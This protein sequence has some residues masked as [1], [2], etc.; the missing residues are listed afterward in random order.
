MR[1]RLFGFLAIALVSFPLPVV[2]GH[3]YVPVQNPA[4]LLEHLVNH[5]D[6]LVTN[7]NLTRTNG[8]RVV[9]EVVTVIVGPPCWGASFYNDVLAVA[10]Q[11]GGPDPIGFEIGQ[12]AKN[13]SIKVI[14]LNEVA[15]ATGPTQMTATA[16][17]QANQAYFNAISAA[18]FYLDTLLRARRQAQW[19]WPV[20]DPAL[21]QRRIDLL[22]ANIVVIQDVMYMLRYSNVF[23]FPMQ[24]NCIE[25]SFSSFRINVA[26]VG[27]PNYY[28]PYY[29]NKQVVFPTAQQVPPMQAPAEFRPNYQVQQWDQ[30]WKQVD[31]GYLAG[32]PQGGAGGVQ[33]GM[34]PR[35]GQPGQ[36]GLGSYPPPQ[37]GQGGRPNQG[38]QGGVGSYPP[39]QGG[40]GGQTNQGQGNGYPLPRGNGS[41]PLPTNGGAGTPGVTPG[42]TGTEQPTPQLPAGTGG[43]F[44]P[45]S[46]DY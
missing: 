8:F 3:G 26:A 44:E 16:W 37:G 45:S 32:G 22:A 6:K 33:G 18:N 27:A 43:T 23:N 39:P 17:D 40:Q 9:P 41:Y 38:G 13:F 11:R 24:R 31:Q 2:A 28:F 46:F 29:A 7:I 10:A 5:A 35:G 1:V 19:P 25:C 42:V 21:L 34:P 12:L 14:Q 36:G 4:V 15:L 30:R 20:N